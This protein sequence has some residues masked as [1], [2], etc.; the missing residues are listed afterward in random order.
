ML[1]GNSVGRDS[2]AF[3]AWSGYHFS[4]RDTVEFGYRQVKG[5][6][7]FLPGGATQSDGTLR[8]SFQLSAAWQADARLQY[9][10][11][12]VPVVGG[13]RR[14]V[15]AVVQVSWQPNLRIYSKESVK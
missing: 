11:F 2:R 6:G 15:S 10:R 8:G 9:E 5:S 4:A 7:A 14:N 3:E 12:W 13:P 1:M